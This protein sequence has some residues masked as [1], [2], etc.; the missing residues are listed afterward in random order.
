MRFAELASHK[1]SQKRIRFTNHLECSVV[2]P[3]VSIV[4]PT[5]NEAAHIGGVLEAAGK[6]CGSIEIIVV[7]GGST[8]ATVAMARAAGVQVLTSACGRGS[9]LRA[10]AAA[11]SGSVFWFL[12]A[13]TAP[14][15]DAVTH[16]MA[17]LADSRVAGGN[18]NLLFAGAGASR[19]LTYVYPRLRVLGLCYGDS[20]IFVRRS[21]CEQIGGLRPYP[22]FEDLDLVRRIH[23]AGR[24][25][26]LPC[27]I[28]TSSRRF[29]G[30]SFTL[31]FC[32]WSLMQI[33]YWC[34]ISPHLL[35]RAY[36]PFREPG[37]RAPV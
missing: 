11:A 34:G 7:D 19:L 22:I 18:F 9:Q 33:L 6:L 15:A 30:R 16:M 29:E 10:G 20:G 28:V 5:L 37:R 3:D 13:D 23:K 8:D 35:A 26:H 17:A 24:F 1:A 32:L 31:T 25:V 12:H 14:P 4:I 27:T 36:R 21:V 2:P